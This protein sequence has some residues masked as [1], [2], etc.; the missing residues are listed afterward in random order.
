V[1]E[2]GKA[3]III[4][5]RWTRSSRCPSAARAELRR[6][7]RGRPARRLVKNDPAVIEAYLG[8]DEEETA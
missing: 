1:N 4:S 5:T 6:P 2:A 7:D 3:I 8:A